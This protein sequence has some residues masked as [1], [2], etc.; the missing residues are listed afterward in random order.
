MFDGADRPPLDK[1]PDFVKSMPVEVAL[2][3]NT[4]IAFEMN[5]APLPHWNGFP[6]RLVV[7]G[8]T[9]T[10]WVKQLAS[11]KAVSSPERTSG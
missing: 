7:P 11:I 4:L 6:A 8:W 2:D 5:G 10:Y 9:G 1:T 3:E